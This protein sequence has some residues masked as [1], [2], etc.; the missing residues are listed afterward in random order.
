M[1]TIGLKRKSSIVKTFYTSSSKNTRNLILGCSDHAVGSTEATS[2]QGKVDP[3]KRSADNLVLTI[4]RRST[5]NLVL[6]KDQRSICSSLIWPFVARRSLRKN[7]W[8]ST[9][10]LER[11]CSSFKKTIQRI[12]KYSDEYNSEQIFVK[13]WLDYYMCL[14]FHDSQRPEK[15][16]FITEPLF[17]GWLKR[18]VSRAL[19][20]HDVSFI[21]SLSKGSK[22]L[23]PELGLRKH[24]DSL[25]KHRSRLSEPH[26]HCPEDLSRMIEFTSK[27]VFYHTNSGHH[28]ALKFLPGAK[29]C[30]QASVRNGGA[31]SLFSQLDLDTIMDSETSQKLGKLRT[32]ELELE[33]CREKEFN[34]A[35]KMVEIEMRNFEEGGENAGTDLFDLDVVAI[36]EP[37]KFRIIT[38]GHGYLYS[39][40]QPVQAM[41]LD[42]WKNHYS[43]TMKVNENLEI[44]VERINRNID[45]F[46]LWCS[47]DYEAATDLIK[48]DATLCALRPL[49]SMPM[50]N[51]VFCCMMASGK[52]H[53]RIHE[54]QAEMGLPDIPDI[55]CIDGQLMGHPLSF[56]L[57]CTIN[58]S[59]YRTTL[60]RWVNLSKTKEEY[61]ER[62]RKKE[63]M[64]KN[65]LVNGDDML[66]K[67]DMEIYT[68][69]MACARD[70][71]LKPSV[72]K[73]YLSPDT[74]MINSQVF[75]NVNGRMKKQGY[76]NLKFLKPSIK[77]HVGEMCSPTQISK[78]LTKMCREV[79]WAKCIIPS[80]FKRWDTDQLKP[81]WYLPVHLGGYGVGLDLS[82]TDWKV[83]RQQRSVARMFL[84]DKN[85]M[86]FRTLGV[87]PE[88]D[89]YLRCRKFQ[90]LIK[91]FSN[92]QFSQPY[93]PLNSHETKENPWMERLCMIK[94]W[95]QAGM[96]NLPSEGRPVFDSRIRYNFQE[97]RPVRFST[98]ESCWNMEFKFTRS[99]ELPPLNVLEIPK[100]LSDEM[101]YDELLDEKYGDE[102]FCVLAT[103]LYKHREDKEEDIEAFFKEEHR[104]L[105]NSYYDRLRSI[106][107]QAM[108]EF[109]LCFLNNSE[110]NID[111]ED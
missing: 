69:F 46:G 80:V 49:T 1:K 23:W 31:L 45:F 19:A 67:C 92:A 74:C 61:D 43:S 68:I 64:W 81:N 29:A 82:P 25:I 65:V 11:V 48:K 98:L 52:L 54:K 93:C 97:Y 35:K 10:E 18:F 34:L 14:F 75:K 9:P 37:C 87:S 57:L 2:M 12:M 13:Y 26:G 104:K 110:E 101:N 22:R 36:P 109:K 71:G 106:W 33:K 105:K 30:L 111:D 8:F 44:E 91:K 51:L 41:M 39:L 58:L 95:S 24:Y 15:S 32:L 50:S 77:L 108:T 5:E 6:T 76:L 40:L 66:F 17:S 72:G 73:N 59:V 99:A 70:A 47:V 38:K 88:W 107:D 16:D 90:D 89:E 7:E 21:Y 42:D 100:K 103:L 83:T 102:C 63:I 28:Q 55:E 56:P 3:S 4:L 53:Y 85:L 86:V 78:D 96:G 62:Q 20:K 79:P 60:E 84:K 94:R 27:E